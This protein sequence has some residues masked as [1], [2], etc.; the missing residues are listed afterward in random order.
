MIAAIQSLY[1]SPTFAVKIGSEQSEWSP[2]DR[3]IRQGCPLSP[4]LFLIVMTVLFRDVHDE[5]NLTRGTLDPLTYTELLY[6]D[7]TVL[8]T[9]NA[10][11][12]NR[13]LKKIEEH[14]AY[15]GL[16]FNKNKC[17][18]LRVNS[19]VSPQ[20]ANG[21]KV[22]IESSTI[23]LGANIND[24]DDPKLDVNTRM[25]SCFATL[26]RLHFFWKKSSCLVRFKL[27][28]FDAVIRSKLVYGLE[29]VN[30]T[31]SLVTE[32]NAFQFKGL[33][34][35]LTIDHTYVNRDNTTVK[36]LQAANDARNPQKL[37]NKNIRPFGEYVQ[38]KQESFLK[39]TVRAPNDDPL[40][41]ALL[42]YNSPVP[43]E[44]VNRR[45]GRPKTSWAENVYE[46][47]WVKSGLGAHADF[48]NDKKSCVL[49]MCEP[50]LSKSI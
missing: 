11:A 47:I 6:A 21:E 2:Q 44:P 45:V 4:Y 41:E 39:H 36:I 46:R 7:D 16:K 25:G 17:V 48:K 18:C 19:N 28:V 34:W 27:N 5:L 37:P 32:L 42:R 10:N 50:I 9:N 35:I 29:A 33:R 23:Y 43:L 8:I 20:F 31:P 12:M 49:N 26:N 22:N 13:M 30:L 3:G 14:A 38:C 24:G 40:R 1:T 15:F